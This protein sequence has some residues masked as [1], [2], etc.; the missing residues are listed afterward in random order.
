MVLER[1]ERRPYRDDREESYS[2]Q[3][4]HKPTTH[5][6]FTFN[7]RNLKLLQVKPIV[8]PLQAI[9]SQGHREN[10]IF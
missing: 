7:G 10:V 9:I 2:E 8:N 5:D 6:I 3:L 4:P 1:D